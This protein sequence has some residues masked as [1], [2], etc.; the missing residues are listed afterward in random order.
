MKEYT[1]DELREMICVI[2]TGLQNVSDDLLKKVKNY[3]EKPHEMLQQD[4]IGLLTQVDR[5]H[6]ANYEANRKIDE[7]KNEFISDMIDEPITGTPNDE[8]EIPQL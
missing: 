2:G 8:P 1:L 3:T 6:R 5:M 7:I 4:I